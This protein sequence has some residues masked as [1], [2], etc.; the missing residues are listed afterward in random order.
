MNKIPSI[1]IKESTN[2]KERLIDFVS[3]NFLPPETAAPI[4]RYQTR[5]DNACPE[6]K[7]ATPMVPDFR[8][9]V[10]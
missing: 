1:P 4:I 5:S 2:Y 6:K 8:A 7:E 10:V 3:K 9:I